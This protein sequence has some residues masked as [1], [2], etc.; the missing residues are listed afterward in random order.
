MPWQSSTPTPLL[1][2][3]TFWTAHVQKYCSDWLAG[4]A[5]FQ[6]FN[7]PGGPMNTCLHV[8][9]MRRIPPTNRQQC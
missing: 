6:A 4:N 2:A 1:L 9:L 3:L 7:G 8:I 5:S